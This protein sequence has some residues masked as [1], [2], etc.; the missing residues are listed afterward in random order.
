[1]DEKDKKSN[2]WGGARKGAGRKKTSAKCT[3]AF[4]I[5]IEL[6]TLIDN[7]FPNRS[8]VINEAIREYLKTR[9]LV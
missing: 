2:G 8:R 7:E 4:S 6:L 1:M 9:E 3:I 5:E